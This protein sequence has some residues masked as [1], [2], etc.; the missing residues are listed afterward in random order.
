MSIIN[1]IKNLNLSNDTQVTLSYEEACDVF[2]HNETAIDTALSDTDVISTLA[3]YEKHHF[4]LEITVPSE[5][6]HELHA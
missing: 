2:V 6:G 4:L 3:E 1:K 5:A